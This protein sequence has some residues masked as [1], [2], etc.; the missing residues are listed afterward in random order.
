MPGSR[1]CAW[2][3][4]DNDGAPGAPKATSEVT[5]L[6]EYVGYC[7]PQTELRMSVQGVPSWEDVLWI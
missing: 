7:S 6:I 1:T 3:E 2:K 4:L 5:Q